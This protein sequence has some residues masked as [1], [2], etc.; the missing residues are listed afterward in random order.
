MLD[1]L[2]GKLEERKYNWKD[3]NTIYE[4]LKDHP[5]IRTRMDL[6]NAWPTAYKVARIAG[7]L[8][9]I[10]ENDRHTWNETTVRELL[11]SHPEIT[12][13]SKLIAANL[14]A[15]KVAKKL[16]LLQ[17]L[18]GGPLEF[19]SYSKE[20]ILDFMKEHPEIKSRKDLKEA[21]SSIFTAAA[22]KHM[23]VGFFGERVYTKR[24]NRQ[25]IEDYLKEH[26]E[27]TSRTKL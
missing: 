4:F 19:K 21:N 25:D 9:E 13:R 18:F 24:W 16:N 8:D 11:K 5:N 14:G 22:K 20:E 26:T 1:E 15:Y 3:E 23:L 6:L 17:E 10:C 2:F 27:I 12:T 7:I